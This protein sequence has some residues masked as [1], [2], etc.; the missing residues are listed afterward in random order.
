MSPLFTYIALALCK[1][2][3]KLVHILKTKQKDKWRMLT[4][5]GKTD[6]TSIWPF[7]HRVFQAYRFWSQLSLSSCCCFFLLFSFTFLESVI[8][9]FSSKEPFFQ[10]PWLEPCT[11]F[12]NISL[13]WLLAYPMLGTLIALLIVSL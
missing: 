4:S 7:V 8:S 1:N 10:C 3:Q 13:H 11:F 12:L 6:F 9:F 2:S 5:P